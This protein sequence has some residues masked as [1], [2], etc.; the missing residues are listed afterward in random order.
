MKKHPLGER[1]A[2]ASEQRSAYAGTRI[3]LILG[4]VTYGFVQLHECY[5]EGPG[6]LGCRLGMRPG[7]EEH[8]AAPAAARAAR[9]DFYHD[10]R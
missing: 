3:G 1:D 5:L 6:P 8:D 2:T 4:D 7:A 9:E 10:A